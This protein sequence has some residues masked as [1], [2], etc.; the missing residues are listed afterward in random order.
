MTDSPTPQERL[1]EA[2]ARLRLCLSKAGYSDERFQ[3]TRHDVRAVIDELER[4]GQDR[5][6]WQRVARRC[7]EEKQAAEVRLEK[8][9]EALANIKW[10]S[11]DK[12]NME[13]TARITYSQMDKIRAAIT[14]AP[15]P[16]RESQL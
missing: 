7:E 10:S 3:P 11:A 14:D 4:R 13:F 8:A 1:E 15:P 16:S 2:V 9:R 5:D 12:D 6:S